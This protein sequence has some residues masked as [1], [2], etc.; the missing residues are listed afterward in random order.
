MRVLI[1]ANLF[2]AY[3]LKPHEQH[4][5][6]LTFDAVA[7]GHV[8]LL[9]PEALLDEIGR[10]VRRKSHLLQLI[11]APQLDRFLTLLQSICEE[12]PR[13]TESIPAVTRDPKDDYL[14]AYA[15]VGQAAYLVSGDKDLLDLPPIPHLTIVDSGQ[16]RQVL[17][18]I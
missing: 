12:I 13:I 18:N 3:L 10:A 6:A 9:A 16:F 11:T 14:L 8:T 1:D 17:L 5:I 2:I 4:I 15:V 7:A